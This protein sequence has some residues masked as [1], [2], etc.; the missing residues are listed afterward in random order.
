M[1]KSIRPGVAHI[2]RIAP[3]R[4]IFFEALNPYFGYFY[5]VNK[6]I[7]KT[8]SFFQNIELVETD[9]FG[10]VLLLD[11]ITQVCERN[12]YSYH[13]PMV[14]PA[15]CCHPKPESVLVIG[16]GDGCLLREILKYP[17]VTRVEVAEI[18]HGVI[19][20]AK[21]YLAAINRNAFESGRLHINITDGRKYIEE[22]PGEFDVIIMDMTDP[23]GPSKMLYTSNFFRLIRRAFRS[24]KG[25]FVM[26]SESPVSRPA[27]FSC[28]GK[29]LR[30]VFT[31]V[32]LLYC[33]IQMYGVLWSIA[34]CSSTVDISLIKPAAIDRMLQKNGIDDLQVYNGAT[35]AA[36][37]VPYPYITKLLR[38]PARIITDNRP[39]FPDDFIF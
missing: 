26:H 36:M 10:K 29:T 27:A 12:E 18:D 34:V 14:H 31:Y 33:Y 13:E 9:E 11:N 8:S 19:H 16:G 6:S 35:H 20:F 30:S 3:R 17:T 32:N 22:H 28:I 1:Q 4:R 39:D 7:R 2:N 25:M 23:F 37:Q 24:E 38:K 21:K 5:T 15:L